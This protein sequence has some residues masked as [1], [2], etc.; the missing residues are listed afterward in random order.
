MAIR[1]CGSGR[2]ENLWPA[3]T[4][5]QPTSELKAHLA[6]YAA[7]TAARAVIH[8]HAANLTT[9]AASPAGRR[10]ARRLAAVIRA[11]PPGSRA[12]ACATSRTAAA[13]PVIIWQDHGVIAWGRTLPQTFVRIKNAELAAGRWLGRH[14]L[15]AMTHT[16]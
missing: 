7:V 10:K 13:H 8:V 12:L 5:F 11:Y 4:R 15:A 14:R 16:E 3:H 1:I 9:L 2:L 6:I